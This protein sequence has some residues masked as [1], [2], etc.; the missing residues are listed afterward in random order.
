MIVSLHATHESADG[1]ECLHD[2]VPKLGNGIGFMIS[3]ISSVQEYVIIS[4]CNR[5]ELY[6]ATDDNEDTVEEFLGMIRKIFPYDTRK[7]TYIL[8]DADSIGHLFR[9]VCGLD[10]LIVGE[11]EIQHQI[12]MAYA[13]A[14]EE[15]HV[16]KIMSHLFD[17]TLAVGK[18]VRSETALN[19]GAVSVGSAA[20]ELA[21]RKLGI[22]DGKNITILGAGDTATVIAKNL[23]GKNPNT[24]FVSNRTFERA[25]ELAAALNGVA[26]PMSR[27]IEAME[28][29]D[30]VLVATSAPHAVLRREHV[31]EVMSRRSDKRLLIID[32]SLPRNVSED[33]AEV[34]NVELDTMDSLE[35]I[36]MENANRRR[37]E[38]NEAEKI[39]GQELA[40]IDAEQREH[41]ADEVIRMISLKLSGI[42]DGE[43]ETAISRSKCI[44]T[45][46]VLDD[47]SRA[48]VNKI[49]AEVYRNL[50]EASRNGR[51]DI[52]DTVAELFGVNENVSKCAHETDEEEQES[53]RPHSRNKVA[54]GRVRAADIL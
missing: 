43:L 21:T 54:P 49:T 26:I 50:R 10:S 45:R 40:K 37:N 51:G 3:N 5:F 15:G 53:K 14:R 1:T 19:K 52:C 47:M 33:V 17:R 12:K 28:F 29:S 46:K 13:K 41:D 44:D 11:N 16:G 39:L 38:V 9:V 35:R 30:L 4:T 6:V 18:R 25:N 2:I 7:M 8:E 36:A 34:S 24:I 27:R 31:E 48:L 22:L 32:V 23:I 20:V 42:R